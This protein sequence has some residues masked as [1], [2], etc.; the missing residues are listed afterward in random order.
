MYKI[1][2]NCYDEKINTVY[3]TPAYAL[4]VYMAYVE[5]WM[6]SQFSAEAVSAGKDVLNNNFP[7]QLKLNGDV[8]L[9]LCEEV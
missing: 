7:H 1:I 5:K 9:E 8:W 3:A 2:G 6:P 4:G